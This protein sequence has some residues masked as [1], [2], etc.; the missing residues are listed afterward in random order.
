MTLI[1]LVR[2][3]T[4]ISGVLAQNGPPAARSHHALMERVTVMIIWI[5]KAYYCVAMTTVQQDQQAWTV[6][7]VMVTCVQNIP[8][9]RAR[10]IA[11]MIQNVKAHLSVDT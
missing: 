8:V 9:K 2:Y 1:V 6:A 11:M 3:A 4:T 10:V 5:V 7:H